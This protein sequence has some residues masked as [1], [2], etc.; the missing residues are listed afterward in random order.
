MHPLVKALLSTWE[1]RPAVS[2]VL[3]LLG[4]LY[5]VGWRRLRSRSQQPKLA[6]KR[7]LA[8]YMSGLAILTISLI[9]PIDR[10]GSQ[11]FFMHMIQHMLMIMVA[12]PLMWLG[13]PF[14]I[15]L[16]GLPV[17]LRQMVGHWFVRDAGFRRLL[18]TA[19]RPGVAWLVFICVFAGW[20]DPNAY[21]L[22]QGREWVHD[23]EHISFFVASLLFWW[24]I[25]G[26]GPHIHGRVSVWAKLAML[27]GMIPV[28]MIAGIVIATASEVIYSYYATVPHIWGFTALEDQAIGGVLMWVSGSE[29]VVWAVVFLLAGFSRA[30]DRNHPL[31]VPP[32][33]S[34]EKMMAPGLEHRIVQNKW[35]KLASSKAPSSEIS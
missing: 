25:V 17:R 24:H 5:G 19:T 10:L 31:P 30:E 33:D 8:A 28:N 6:T 11:L 34:E 21:N 23:L 4:T 2:G 16:W 22:A 1:W 3:L 26:A 7:R 20:H 15:G 35:R 29:M 27:I 14:P 18:S 9:S 32:W 12:A 13:E